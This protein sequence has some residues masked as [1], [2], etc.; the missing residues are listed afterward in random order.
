MVSTTT[1]IVGG[2]VK[3]SGT[4]AVVV[5]VVVVVVAAR[6]DVAT[7]GMAAGRDRIASTSSTA[8]AAAEIVWSRVRVVIVDGRRGGQRRWGRPEGTRTV[9]TGLSVV[10]ILLVQRRR[11]HWVTDRCQIRQ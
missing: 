11:V 3:I 2:V 8:T 6:A 10:V 4:G 1:A 7:A 9:A 5:V